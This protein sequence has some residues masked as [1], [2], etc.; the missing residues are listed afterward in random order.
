MLCSV[1]LYRQTPRAEQLSV[2]DTLTLQGIRELASKLAASPLF[3]VDPDAYGATS[4]TLPAWDGGL[5]LLT[6]LRRRLRWLG[7]EEPT[8]SIDRPPILEKEVQRALAWLDVAIERRYRPT[9]QLCALDAL[10]LQ[11]IREL[12]SKL[13]ASLLFGTDPDSYTWDGDIVLVTR[14]R[15]RLDWLATEEPPTLAGQPIREEDVQRAYSWLCAM[16][17]GA[18]APMPLTAPVTEDDEYAGMCG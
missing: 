9:E 18:Y 8:T 3:G 12:A 10:A 14:L 2:V 11:G 15:R 13:A 7:S 6:R 4:R 16:G 5:A 1:S 17:R